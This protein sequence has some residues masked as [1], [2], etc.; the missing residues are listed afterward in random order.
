MRRRG[1]V[2]PRT[3]SRALP[4]QRPGRYPLARRRGGWAPPMRRGSVSRGSGPDGAERR[5]KDANSD[6]SAPRD[7]RGD[8]RGGYPKKKR[9]GSI[10]RG[11][12]RRRR[13]RRKRKRRSRRRKRK[14]KRRRR[15]SRR[16]IPHDATG[17]RVARGIHAPSH[18]GGVVH[19]DRPGLAVGQI[20]IPVVGESFVPVVAPIAKQRGAIEHRSGSRRNTRRN[21]PAP[22]PQQAP[23]R[24]SMRG[25]PAGFLQR[26]RVEFAGDAAVRAL[27]LPRVRGRDAGIGGEHTAVQ[28]PAGPRDGERE[29]GPEGQRDDE[30]SHQAGGAQAVGRGADAGQRGGSREWIRG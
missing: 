6:V 30:G 14:R 13:R 12:R 1:L 23:R 16:R 3:R 20:Q 7:A 24:P 15:R 5:R 27:V 10:E 4:R 2:A 26:G 8:L 17:A 11:R 25:V 19:R 22:H 9:N 28:V 21:A 18:R 29:P